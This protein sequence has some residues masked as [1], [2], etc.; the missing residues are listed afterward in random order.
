MW[1][2]SQQITEPMGDGEFSV[3]VCACICACMCA[4]VCMCVHVCA[5]MCACMWVVFILYKDFALEVCM[6]VC[7]VH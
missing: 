6:L 4:C 2:F 3:H 1:Y 5:C 7:P